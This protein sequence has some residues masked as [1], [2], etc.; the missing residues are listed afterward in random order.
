MGLL[1]DGQPAAAGA[2]RFRIR[3]GRLTHG[4]LMYRGE[5]Y[6]LPTAQLGVD[7][8]FSLN[9][10]SESGFLRLESTW[11]EDA[12]WMR[13]TYSGFIERK[14]VQGVFSLAAQ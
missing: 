14:R 10:T 11:Q 12:S 5:T 6:V 8:Q 9:A 3:N 2:I 13:G 4:T 7:G 1:Q